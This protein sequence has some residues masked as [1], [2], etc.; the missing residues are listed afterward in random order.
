[1]VGRTKAAGVHLH[2]S[3][4]YLSNIDGRVERLSKVHHNVCPKYEGLCMDQF[5]AYL[6]QDMVVSGET[7]HLHQRTAHTVCKVVERISRVCPRNTHHQP[8][9]LLIASLEVISNIWCCME[10]SC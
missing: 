3:T 4:L 9:A 8:Q 5:K 1:M 6:P 2:E 10:A 7:I